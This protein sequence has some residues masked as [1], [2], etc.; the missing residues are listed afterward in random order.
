MGLDRIN[1]IR[2]EKGMNIEDLARVSN[3][4]LSTLRKLCAG[5]TTNPSLETVKAIAKALDCSLD[6]FDDTKKAPSY[7]T[8]LSADALFIARCFERADPEGQATL[9]RVAEYIVKEARPLSRNE[10]L[11][12]AQAAAKYL[13]DTL[14]SR[15]EI[16]EA[17][18]MQKT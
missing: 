4:P 18:G 5:I 11:G 10:V 2:K 1:D 9:L 7:M 15:E 13:D 16:Q 12:E 17:V 14:G 6:E 3:V 8:E